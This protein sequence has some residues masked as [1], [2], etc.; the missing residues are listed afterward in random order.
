MPEGDGAADE[1][2]DIVDKAIK[3]EEEATCEA[4]ED[5]LALVKL[6]KLELKAELDTTLA[7]ELDVE[8][9]TGSELELATEV[10][11]TALLDIEDDEG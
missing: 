1:V 3:L 11:D 8:L 5:S 4:E 10:T 2:A 6:I 9:D 7:A